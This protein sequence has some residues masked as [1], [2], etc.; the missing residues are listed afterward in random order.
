MIVGVDPGLNGAVALLADDGNLI[1]VW[2]MPVVDKKVSPQLLRQAENWDA[3]WTCVIEDVHAMPK[4]G[5]SSV[6]SFG[7][8]KGIVEGVF[9][10]MR[11]EY[12]SPAQWKRAMKLT[13]DKTSARGVAIARWPEHA[14]KFKLV[15]NDGRAEAALIAEWF[16][17]KGQS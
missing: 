2:D 15:K 1:D 14:D 10:I 5:V 7:R 3:S 11:L 4:Q 6:F 8:S 9:S 13:S 17:A 16:R 12:V